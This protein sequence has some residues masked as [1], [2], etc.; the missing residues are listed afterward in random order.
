MNHPSRL[1]CVAATTWLFIRRVV[2]FAAA[3]FFLLL[4]VQLVFDPSWTPDILRP[5]KHPDDWEKLKVGGG[6]LLFCTVLVFVG[7]YGARPGVIGAG[8]QYAGIADCSRL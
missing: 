6:I 7:I 5:V 1:E 2:C 4:F 8:V 3:I